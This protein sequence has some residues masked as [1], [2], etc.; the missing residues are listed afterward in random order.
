MTDNLISIVEHSILEIEIHVIECSGLRSSLP[1]LTSFFL[2]LWTPPSFP[3]IYFHIIEPLPTRLL[4]LAERV[5]LH[6]YRHCP[7]HFLHL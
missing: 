3:N 7:F 4:R 1:P 5:V 6:S 2:V